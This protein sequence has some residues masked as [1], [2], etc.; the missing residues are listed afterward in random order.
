MIKKQRV[1]LIFDNYDE[2]VINFMKYQEGG[3][4]ISESGI[5]L[6]GWYFKAEKGCEEEKVILVKGVG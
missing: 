2:Y 4:A 6:T 1:E 5:N 3:F